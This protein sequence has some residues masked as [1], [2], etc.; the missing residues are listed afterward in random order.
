VRRR[1]LLELPIL[2]SDAAEQDHQLATG[3]AAATDATANECR[4]HLARHRRL[5]RAASAEGGRRHEPH[6]GRATAFFTM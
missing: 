1:L 5:D 3:P 4:Q 2:L 6:E